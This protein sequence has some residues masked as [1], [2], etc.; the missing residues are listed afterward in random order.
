MNIYTLVPESKLTR[1]KLS[2]VGHVLMVEVRDYILQ[3]KSSSSVVSL[4][5]ILLSLVAD[6]YEE[7]NCTVFDVL[8]AYLNA[9][10][11]PKKVSS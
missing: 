6:G 5:S 2:N 9:S 8:G 1:E 10:M 11:L 7:H 3:I 4:D